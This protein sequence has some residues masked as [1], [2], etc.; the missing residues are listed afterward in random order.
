MAKYIDADLLRKEIEKNKNMIDGLFTEGDD[1]VYD[2]ENDAYNRMLCII[3]S[4][5]QEPDKNL[6][7]AAEKYRRTSCNAAMKP[8]IDGPMPEYGGNVKTAF[9]D[10]AN[11]QK[12]KDIRDMIMS[13]NR[14]FQKV[15]E[16]GKKD[17]MEKM[18]QDKINGIIE[19][20]NGKE[21]KK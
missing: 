6:E 20:I 2:G 14:Q 4:I 5:Q 12:E 19:Y 3:D 11:W 9:I 10:G 1:S 13:D 17:M 15:Y 16:L 7:E 8:N 21:E 18:I